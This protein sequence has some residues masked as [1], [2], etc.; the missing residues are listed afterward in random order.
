MSK[1]LDFDGL[2]EYDEEIKKIIK[3]NAYFIGTQ[4]EYNT[5]CLDGLICDGMLIVIT[6]DES[7]Q[8]L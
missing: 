8:V 6:N 4:E 1:Y 2:K 7:E 3:E 5:A